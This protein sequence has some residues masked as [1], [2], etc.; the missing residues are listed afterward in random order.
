[1]ASKCRHPCHN[2]DTVGRSVKRRSLC[3]AM[4][5]KQKQSCETRELDSA[6][7]ECEKEQSEIEF[8]R[9]HPINI[10][11]HFRYS[12]ILIER[13]NTSIRSL[14]LCKRSELP[15]SE[16]CENCNDT[17]SNNGH[18]HPRWNRDRITSCV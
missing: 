11:S 17:N 2:T 14:I 4:R 18:V 15:L 13:P 16:P 5:P 6:S 7:A 8:T 9:T 10:G 3:G 1:M 12:S